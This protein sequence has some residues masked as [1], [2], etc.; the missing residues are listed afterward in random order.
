MSWFDRISKKLFSAEDQMNI[1]EVLKRTPGFIDDY[2]KWRNQ[3]MFSVLKYDILKSWQLY[4][5]NEELPVDITIFT[6]DYANGFI[7][8]PHYKDTMIPLAFLMEF[9]K[10]KLV[11]IGYNLTHADRKMHEVQ[12]NVEIIEKYYLKP[13][14]SSTIP[15]DQLYGNVVIELLKL[16]QEEVRI[17]FLVN[18]YSDRH[19]SRAK[20]F[21]ELLSVIFDN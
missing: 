18:I 10:D 5:N 3:D 14:R 9:F 8:Y 15:K 4:E 6:S 17:Q 1:H 11:N 19:Y 21:S 16:G 20:D 13:S 2:L 12:S 7:I